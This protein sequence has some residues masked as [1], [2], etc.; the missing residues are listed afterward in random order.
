MTGERKSKEERRAELEAMT[1]QEI[2]DLLRQHN[3]FGGY[4]KVEVQRHLE[5]S[6]ESVLRWEDYDR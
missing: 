1:P 6:I 4:S 2:V 3:P 5:G